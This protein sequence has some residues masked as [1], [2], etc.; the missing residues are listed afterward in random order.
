M[1]GKHLPGLMIILGT[2]A[3]AAI[4]GRLP[5][6]YT[7]LLISLGFLFWIAAVF[8]MRSERIG[9]LISEVFLSVP[10]WIERQHMK[11]HGNSYEQEMERIL[12]VHDPSALTEELRRVFLKAGRKLPHCED[13]PRDAQETIR[14]LPPVLQDFFKEYDILELD[15]TRIP[16][17]VRILE[18]LRIQ[19]TEYCVIGRNWE[20][21]Y[22]TYLIPTGC[23]NPPVYGTE[24]VSKS[25]LEACAKSVEQFVL[26]Q[27]AIAL[28]SNERRTR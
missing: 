14:L 23:S 22:E 6:I 15:E 1:P 5:W 16:L 17:D 27:R 2:C 11:K 7:L 26:V 24:Q 10:R 19:G 9:G 12:N 4:A 18:T 28:D 3:I 20:D 8:L 21:D 13:S 25:P